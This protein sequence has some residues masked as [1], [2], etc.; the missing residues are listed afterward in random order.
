MMGKAKTN[1][2][3]VPMGAG[4]LYGHGVTQDGPSIRASWASSQHGSLLIFR[5]L[6]SPPAMVV[7]DYLN[8]ISNILQKVKLFCDQVSEITVSLLPYSDQDGRKAPPV[9]RESLISPLC[10]SIQVTV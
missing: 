3:Y 1:S 4:Y 6:C 8:E 7:G 2:G 9:S 5:Q 10:R